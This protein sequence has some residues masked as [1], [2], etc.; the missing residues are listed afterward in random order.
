MDKSHKLPLIMTQPFVRSKLSLLH[1]CLDMERPLPELVWCDVCSAPLP[2]DGCAEC[3]AW[4]WHLDC[5]KTACAFIM[6][7]KCA[8]FWQQEVR[9]FLVE[10]SKLSKPSNVCLS[11]CPCGP[12]FH[13]SDYDSNEESDEEPRSDETLKI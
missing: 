4:K 10:A 3:D 2:Q 6:T 8:S 11:T 9:R 1:V 13:D 7:S 12:V 5:Q